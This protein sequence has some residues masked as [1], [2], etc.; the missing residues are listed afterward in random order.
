MNLE[1]LLLVVTAS[2]LAGCSSPVIIQPAE[3]P[4][5]IVPEAAKDACGAT[6]KLAEGLTYGDLPELARQ[7]RQDFM[8]CRRAYVLLASAYQSCVDDLNHF[9]QSLERL[10]REAR[11]RQKGAT[12]VGG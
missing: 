5:C 4:V 6:A 11:E 1:R 3:A 7:T 10:K 12:L 2:T 8:E 9:N